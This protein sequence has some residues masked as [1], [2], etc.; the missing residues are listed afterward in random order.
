MIV[1]GELEDQLGVRAACNWAK[2][3]VEIEGEVDHKMIVKV[4]EEQGYKVVGEA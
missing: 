2:Q 4:I 3:V 1:E